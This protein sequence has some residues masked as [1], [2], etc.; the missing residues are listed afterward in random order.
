VW[1]DFLE[2]VYDNWRHVHCSMHLLT[3][4]GF[5]FDIGFKGLKIRFGSMRFEMSDKVM[6]LN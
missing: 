6:Y 5:Q 1:F 3:E 4:A 2:C